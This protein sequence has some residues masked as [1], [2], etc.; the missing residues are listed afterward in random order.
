MSRSFVPVVIALGLLG[1]LVS[2]I[3]LGW[4]AKGDAD[5]LSQRLTAD[6]KTIILDRDGFGGPRTIA[7]TIQM[8]GCEYVAI[9][10]VGGNEG[11]SLTHAANCHNPAHV[12]P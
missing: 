8:N 9:M 7:R 3:L 5:R 6:G 12:R 10:G 1:V 11:Q 2:P 4:N